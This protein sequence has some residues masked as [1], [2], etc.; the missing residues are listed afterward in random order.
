MAPTPHS[1][2]DTWRAK[3]HGRGMR[4]FEQSAQ[5]LLHTCIGSSDAPQIRR[6]AFA[7]PHRSARVGRVPLATTPDIE[8]IR[9]SQLADPIDDRKLR[10][11]IANGRWTRIA[12]GAFARTVEWAALKPI[13]QHR[14]RV[15]EAER[16]M[17]GT[18]VVSH[19][20]AAA[21]WGIDVLGAWPDDVDVTRATAGG[22][23]SSGGIRRHTVGLDGLELVRLGPHHVTTPAQTA[24]DLARV[25]PFTHAVAVIDQAIWS[26]RNG[27]A[28]TT[29]DA[30]LR[31]HEIGAHHR[32][33][34]RALRAISFANPLAANVRES[35]SRVLIA[36][37]GFPTPR[38]QERRILR[39]GRLVYGD[40]FWPDHD[41][42][43]ELDGKGKYRSP[44]FGADR[45]EWMIVV[46][47]K[48]REN[49]IRR[50][51]RGFSRWEPDDADV[52]RRMYD[53][54]SG[55]GLTS[56]LPRPSTSASAP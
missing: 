21:R 48:N 10:R 16:R 24:L 20:A 43:G 26:G 27:G 35:Q 18:S 11:A 2:A 28:L 3:L 29:V 13:E 1:G 32:G 38:L 50:E 42:W 6:P 8:I 55:D 49:E 36:Q 54:L 40:F 51:V 44:E 33:S 52:P 30:I 15:L 46:D 34:V 53:I 12:P 5:P 4:L 23:R 25:L 56:A 31:L 45:A 19:F 9:R 7:H 22:G 14:L 47:E 41:H 17:R 39:T 37:L